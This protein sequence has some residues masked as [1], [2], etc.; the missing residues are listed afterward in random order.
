MAR[1]AGHPEAIVNA[2]LTVSEKIRR[3]AAAGYSRRQIADL[4]ERSYQQVR[5]VLVE[6]LR[7][8][9]RL[10]QSPQGVSEGPLATY[11]SPSPE[12]GV[13][14]FPI[15]LNGEIVLPE[16]LERALGLYRGGVVVAEFDGE[17]LVILSNAAA[18]AQAQAFVRSLQIPPGVSLADELIADRRREAELEGGDG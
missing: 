6:D 17:R 4:V 1:E 18:I 14:R 16:A 7:R 8:A 2:A 5:Q 11:S 13:Y 3:L 12:A 9:K 15:G 10:G